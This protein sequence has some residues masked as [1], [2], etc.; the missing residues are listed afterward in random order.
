MD[1]LRHLDIPELSTLEPKWNIPECLKNLISKY[2][3]EIYILALVDCWGRNG[4]KTTKA[5]TE[6]DEF[7]N[8]A[9]QDFK[10]VGHT[11]K[12]DYYLNYYLENLNTQF[13]NCCSSQP[14]IQ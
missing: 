14:I 7:E 8:C 5:D 9:P 12:G 10:Y 6:R 1:R 4:T 13:G 3:P 2:Q 11:K